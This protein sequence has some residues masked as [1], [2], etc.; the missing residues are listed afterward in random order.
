MLQELLNI[1]IAPLGSTHYD[2]CW[3]FDERTAP[4]LVGELPAARQISSSITCGGGSTGACRSRHEVTRTPRA[5]R[6]AVCPPGMNS[7]PVR[8]V[9][10]SAFLRHV[11]C[12]ALL[13]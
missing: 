13:C 7:L 4:A 8:F 1:G 11:L 3:F 5:V 10:S 2:A 6:I 9:R 12:G